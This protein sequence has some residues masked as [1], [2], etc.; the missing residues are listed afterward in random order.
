V[1]HKLVAI[2]AY[3]EARG[4][5]VSG[6]VLSEEEE[7]RFEVTLSDAVH[8][9]F[10]TK[11]LFTPRSRR[12]TKARAFGS[13]AAKAATSMDDREKTGVILFCVLIGCP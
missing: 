5:R 10:H 8:T 4:E 3:Y 6:V 11:V 9:H 1:L 12:P 2:H 13:V 7:T